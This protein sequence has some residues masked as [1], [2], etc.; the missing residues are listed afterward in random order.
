MKNA[1]FIILLF[2]GFVCH[3]KV[4]KCFQNV[5]FQQINIKLSRKYVIFLST[6]NPRLDVI[7]KIARE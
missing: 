6:P 1:K 3:E 2:S 7:E 4:E 5:K